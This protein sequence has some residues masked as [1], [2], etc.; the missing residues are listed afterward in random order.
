MRVNFKTHICFCHKVSHSEGSKI[1]LF[2]TNNDIYVV[3]MITCENALVAYNKLLTD[4]YYDVSEYE[5]N[6]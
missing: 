2:T 3:D 4:G 5:Y 1:L 6:N